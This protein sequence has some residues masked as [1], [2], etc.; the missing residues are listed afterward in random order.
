MN[1]LLF[2]IVLCVLL[3]AQ[4]T[5]HVDSHTSDQ[6]VLE[7]DDITLMCRSAKAITDVASNANWK[8]CLWQREQDSSSCLMEYKCKENCHSIFHSAVWEVTTTCEPALKDITYFGSDPNAENHICGI[9]VP[10]ARPEDNSTWTCDVSNIRCTYSI[11]TIY[12]SHSS[13][14]F[15]TANCQKKKIQNLAFFS[16]FW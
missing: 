16:R 11:K 8:S 10:N 7:G 4:A 12:S 5:W 14:I 2:A 3:P 9:V 1:L 6:D 15:C 13:H